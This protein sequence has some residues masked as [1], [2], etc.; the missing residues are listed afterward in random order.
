MCAGRSL[1]RAPRDAGLD[2]GGEVVGCDLE[3]A[4]EAREIEADAASLGNDM[5]FQARA[6]TE[7]RHRHAALVGEREHPRD[8]R[9]RGRVDDE[10]RALRAVKRD[11]A[12]VEIELR[13]SIRDS[14]ALAE[15]APE[16]LP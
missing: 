6:G 15:D 5:S 2:G 1:E 3:D 4:V 14:S 16:R 7:R 11:V 12:G 10:L 9:G 13:V 8:V